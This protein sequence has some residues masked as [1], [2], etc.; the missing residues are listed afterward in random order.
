MHKGSLYHI[1]CQGAKGEVIYHVDGLPSGAEL[2]GDSILVKSSAKS[3]NFILRIKAIFSDGE[4][5]EQII[6]LSI[7]NGD[8]E[9][10][11]IDNANN[12]VNSGN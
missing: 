2:E 12:D 6:T 8:S 7:S 10:N 4:T 3:G 9:Q 1:S 5:A 11:I